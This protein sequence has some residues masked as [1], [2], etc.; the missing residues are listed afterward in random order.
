MLLLCRMMM[1]VNGT[2]LIV[3]ERSLFCGVEYHEART[4]GRCS[5]ND[6]YI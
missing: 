1:G 4:G 2:A 6:V 5:C 3:A